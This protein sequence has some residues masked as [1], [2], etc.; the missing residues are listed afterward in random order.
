MLQKSYITYT[1]NETFLS[2]CMV[3]TFWAF[4]R[5]T[6]LFFEKGFCCL[7]KLSASC[8]MLTSGV[9]GKHLWEICVMVARGKY[10]RF[11]ICIYSP[12]HVLDI[13]FLIRE[14]FYYNIFVRVL[15]AR[16]RLRLNSKSERFSAAVSFPRSHASISPSPFSPSDISQMPKQIPDL[17]GHPIVVGREGSRLARS[18]TR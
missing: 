1:W 6:F 4:L 8:Q 3:I 10:I 18:L 7:V 5:A 11:I 15:F 12:V 2:V 9:R 13:Q 17:M 14:I 16:A